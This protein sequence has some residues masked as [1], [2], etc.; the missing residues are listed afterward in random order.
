MAEPSCPNSPKAWQ[1][2]TGLSC[3]TFPGMVILYRGTLLEARNY[4]CLSPCVVTLVEQN[5]R[6]FLADA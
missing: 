5:L 1:D 6:T 3:D 4:A 2:L